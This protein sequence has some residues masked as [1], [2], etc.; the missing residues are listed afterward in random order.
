MIQAIRSNFYP[1]RVEAL[2]VLG[3][4]CLGHSWCCK[5]SQVWIKLGEAAGLR[6][7]QY[8]FERLGFVMPEQVEVGLEAAEA[9]KEY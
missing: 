1:L 7:Y 5:F 8:S 6:Y 4:S 3:K 9:A 2:V